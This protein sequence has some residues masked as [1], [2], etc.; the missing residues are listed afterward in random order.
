MLW[1]FIGMHILIT[2]ITAIT[3]SLFT[4]VPACTAA[5]NEAVFYSNTAV[6]NSF[7]TPYNTPT[8]S[9]PTF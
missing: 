9:I 7:L 5:V 3:T 8:V 4:W 6:I 2:I 1:V